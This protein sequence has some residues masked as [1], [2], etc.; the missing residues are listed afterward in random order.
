MPGSRQSAVHALRR[1]AG[2]SEQNRDS[3]PPAGATEMLSISRFL[4]ELRHVARF[5]SGP[6][7]DDPLN[8]VVRKIEMNPAFAQ[9]RLLARLLGALTCQEGEFRRAEVSAF[10]ADTLLLALALMQA[11]AA[12][13]FKQEE[14]INAV[15]STRTALLG[16]Q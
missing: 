16:A 3:K 10:D 8:A 14:W 13:A 6:P 5:R 7:I 9:S 11:R 15:E 1:I 2:V 4:E 12:A